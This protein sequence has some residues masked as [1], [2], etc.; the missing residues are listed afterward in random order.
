MFCNTQWTV[1]ANCLSGV[2][3]YLDELQKLWDWSLED[4]SCLEMKAR[5]CGI[6]VYT[7]KFS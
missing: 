2:I 6:K 1:C 4:C 7:H 5:I 3:R